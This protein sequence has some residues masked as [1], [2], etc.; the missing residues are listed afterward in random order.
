MI[1]VQV[2]GYKL[3]LAD[4]GIARPSA[5]AFRSGPV[6]PAAHL[7][8]GFGHVTVGAGLMALAMVFRA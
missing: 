2:P 4:A 7:Q 5:I 8:I 3:Q 6:G 1:F